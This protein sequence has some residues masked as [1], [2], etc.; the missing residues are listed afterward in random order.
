[1]GVEEKMKVEENNFNVLC[2]LSVNLLKKVRDIIP[3]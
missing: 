2:F 1:M 3:K